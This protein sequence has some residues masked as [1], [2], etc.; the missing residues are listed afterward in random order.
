M[1]QDLMHL[2]S[3]MLE[4]LVLVS[5]EMKPKC[6]LKADIL[7]TMQKKINF[8]HATQ[9]NYPK[10]SLKSTGVILITKWA[11]LMHVV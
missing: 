9:G 3:W 4:T 6:Y 1:I 2:F 7:E 8:H 11:R 10:T 5:S